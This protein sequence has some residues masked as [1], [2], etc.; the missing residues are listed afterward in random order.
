MKNRSISEADNAVELKLLRAFCF[1]QLQLQL[2]DFWF[3]YV[4]GISIYR[5]FVV[6]RMGIWFYSRYGDFRLIEVRF[7][8]VQL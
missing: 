1:L 6:V 8:E 4:G 7:K 5:R 3:K 2:T